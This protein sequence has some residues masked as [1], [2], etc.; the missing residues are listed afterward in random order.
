M[1]SL[2]E[3]VQEVPAMGWITHYPKSEPTSHACGKTLCGKSYRD[4]GNLQIH[5]SP[6]FVTC[7][8]CLKRLQS[9]NPE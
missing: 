9:E 3:A 2:N 5:H 8:T 6:K 1:S 7:P 4:G